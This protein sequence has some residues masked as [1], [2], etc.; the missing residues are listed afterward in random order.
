MRA[1]S[2]DE[3]DFTVASTSASGSGGVFLTAFQHCSKSK[4]V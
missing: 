3:I 1:S 4:T 2:R